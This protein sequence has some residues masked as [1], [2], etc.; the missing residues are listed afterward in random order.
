MPSRDFLR[1]VTEFERFPDAL[2]RL[3][4]GEDENAITVGIEFILEWLH[5]NRRVNHDR[6]EGRYRYRG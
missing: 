5:L 2:R 1:Y 6:M 3:Q 4:V